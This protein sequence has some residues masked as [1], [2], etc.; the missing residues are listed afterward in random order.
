MRIMRRSVTILTFCASKEH[1]CGKKVGHSRGRVLGGSSAINVLALIYPSKSSIDAWSRLGNQ[2]WDFDSL[3]PYYRKFHTFNRPSKQTAEA[4]A[5]DYI[6]E[7]VSGTSG[8][9]QS[10][11]PE[12]HGPLGK[13]WP[14]TFKN[15]HFAM[16]TDPLSGQSTG[17]F[18]YLSSVDP[19]SWERSHAGSA[20][21][22]PVADRP[23]LHL[24]TDAYVEKVMID[25]SES[26]VVATGVQFT[27][28]GRSEVRKA[29]NEVLLCAGVFQS[30]QILELSGIGS[31]KL[32]QS[33][34]IDVKVE[35]PHVG[36]NMQDHPMSGMCFEVVEGLPTIDMIRDPSVIQGA[37]EAYQSARAGPLTSA[38]HSIASLPVVEFLSGKGKEELTQLL[39]T[40]IPIH[41]SSQ[42]DSQKAQHTIL[43]SILESPSHGSVVIGMGASQLHF[44]ASL[45]KDIYAITDPA[46]Y[47]CFLVSLAHPFSR[48][49]VHINSAS[50][51]AKPTIDPRYLSH[52]LDLE[53]FARHVRYIPTIAATEPL[54]SLLKEGGKRLPEGMDISTL[55]AARDHVRRNLIT[56]NHPCG[57]CAML[58]REAHGVVDDR[59]KV[60]GVKRLRVVD[61]SIFPMIPRGNIQSSVYAVAEKAADLI[62]EDWGLN[63]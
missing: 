39:D 49:S 30:P 45:Q 47:A 7:G 17:G 36:E 40:H 32:L 53:I 19:K 27:Y 31:P 4:L 57:T 3:A 63:K 33:H 25:Q 9:I 34:G 43:R 51:S 22:A 29:R 1:L 10:S 8:P 44:P 52:P 38:F 60:Y 61:A 14:E 50:P 5:T 48:G 18:S 24:L 35:N 23:N 58:P 12:F 6:D 37:I 15:L 62:K 54:A 16:T 20:Y 56:N 28:N 59:L 46:N 41:S 26:A 21:Y 13:A 11:F 55:D 2:G 42:T